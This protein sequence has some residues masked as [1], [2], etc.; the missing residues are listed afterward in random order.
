MQDWCLRLIA[1]ERK[2]RSQRYSHGDG[3]QSRAARARV[4]N[5]RR[6]CGDHHLSEIGE[7]V[8]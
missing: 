4:F 6:E 1:T 7:G 5:R 3:Q 2:V 8:E